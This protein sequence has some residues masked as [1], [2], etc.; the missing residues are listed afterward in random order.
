ML[1]SFPNGMTY[2]IKFMVARSCNLDPVRHLGHVSHRNHTRFHT[3]AIP[4]QHQTSGHGHP[5]G[6][7][8]RIPSTSFYWGLK[9]LLKPVEIGPKAHDHPLCQRVLVFFQW[10]HMEGIVGRRRRR[11]PA[12][13][14]SWA[15]TAASHKFWNCSS[16]PAAPVGWTPV[17]YHGANPYW[18]PPWDHQEI[19]IKQSIGPSSNSAMEKTTR[20]QG[21]A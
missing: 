17:V 18:A 8:L 7:I 21:H 15:A 3:C 16:S 4:I 14:C 5:Q 2:Y 20:S 13:D 1:N 11:P 10:K 12:V 19:I 9:T 6:G